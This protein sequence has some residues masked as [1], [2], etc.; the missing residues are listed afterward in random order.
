MSFEGA[1]KVFYFDN[2]LP[3]EERRRVNNLLFSGGGSAGWT[4]GW[5]SHTQKDAF[6]FWHRHFAGYLKFEDEHYDCEPELAKFP[7]LHTFWQL[8]AAKTLQGHRLVRC[9]ANGQ[10]YGSDGTLHVDAAAPNN[11]TCVYYPHREWHPD[12]AGE[13]VFFNRDRTDVIATVYPRPNRLAVFDGTLP[14]VARGVSRTCPV[15]RVT[16][17]FKTDTLDDKQKSGAVPAAASG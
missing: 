8:L 14:H 16:L 3:D 15:L 1:S 6:S 12:W 9:Y 2:V 5:K 13:T 11:Y 17:M 10:A 4:F 7:L